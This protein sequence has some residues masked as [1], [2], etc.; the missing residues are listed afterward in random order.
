M[1]G[2]GDG[3]R[4]DWAAYYALLKDRPPR[5]TTVFASRRFQAPGFAVDLGCGGGRD[6]LPLLATGWRV[7][8][9]DREPA[10]LAALTEA[11]PA[12]WRDRLETRLGSF[13]EADWPQADLIIAAFSLQFTPKPAFPALWRRIR[14]RLAPGGRFA[15]HL[16]G[17][18]DSWAKGD[19]PDGAVAFTRAECLAL[20]QGLEIELFE[21]EEHDGQTP[22]GTAKHWH[23]FHIVARKPQAPIAP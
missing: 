15:G 12:E 11:A 18:R 16:I 23:I 22:R 3:G 19:A 6:S 20:L 7:L 1:T 13:V 4:K 9:I 5:T 21:E 2:W 8:G 14:E 17:A 10:A